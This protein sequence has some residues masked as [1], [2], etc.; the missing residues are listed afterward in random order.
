MTTRTYGI[1][2][3]IT[4]DIVHLKRKSCREYKYSALFVDK[5]SN[6][7]FAYQPKTRPFHSFQEAL[8]SYYSQRFL[9]CLKMRILRTDFDFLVLDKNFNDVLIEKNFRLRTSAPYKHQQS[10]SSVVL[11]TAFLLSWHTTV[12]QWTSYALD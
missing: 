6:K 1:F 5:C 2:E 8:T 4:L 10:A 3:Y 9:R 11:R 12:L 7:T